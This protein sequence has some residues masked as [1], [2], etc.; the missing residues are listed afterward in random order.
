MNLKHPLAAAVLASGLPD[1][2]QA[3]YLAT[4]AFTELNRQAAEISD[5]DDAR[6]Q[7][8]L[9]EDLAARPADR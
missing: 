6:F 5:L 8:S 9:A 1:R 4:A 3:A 2:V 7:Q